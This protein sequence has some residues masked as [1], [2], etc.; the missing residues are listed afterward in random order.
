[1]IRW[2]VNA[3]LSPLVSLGGKYLDN[4]NDKAKLE[5]GITQAAHAADYTLSGIKLKYTLLRLP[6]FIAE[7][8]CAVYVA[9]ILID[10]TFPMGWL[11]PLELPEWF[12][13]SFSM[14]CASIFGLATFERVVGRR[15]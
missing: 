10:S 2:L 4:Q 9:A 8:A 15:K 3:L 14:I 5:A 1:M 12:K 7:T 6:L 13:P 11:T